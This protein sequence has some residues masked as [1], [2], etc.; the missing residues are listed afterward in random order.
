MD[1]H[2]RM[3]RAAKEF[4]ELGLRKKAE[5]RWESASGPGSSLHSAKESLELIRNTVIRRNIRSILDLGCGDWHWMR[6][7]GLPD[8]GENLNVA[9]EGWDAN[10]KAIDQ[11]NADYGRERISFKVKD[12][13]ANAMPR[14]DLIIARDV[15]FHLPQ[16]L[17]VGVVE[18][19][20]KSARYL[21]STSFLGFTGEDQVR[22]FVQIDGWGFYKINL[23]LPPFDLAESMVEAVREENCA[24]SGNNRFVCLY[25]FDDDAPSGAENG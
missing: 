15:L 2:Q 19:A 11:L 7:L 20:K 3:F 21:I 22:N 9:Y 1:E 10:E 17:A 14:V 24:Y 8:L 16:A 12:I 13:T 4:V 18:R 6:R 25:E 5:G 23:N